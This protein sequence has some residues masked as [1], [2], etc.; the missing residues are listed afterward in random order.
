MKEWVVKSFGAGSSSKVVVNSVEVSVTNAFSVLSEGENAFDELLRVIVHVCDFKEKMTKESIV[1]QLIDND[2]SDDP[3]LSEAIDE[4]DIA[5]CENLDNNQGLELNES[6][7]FLEQRQVVVDT[8]YIEEILP[9]ELQHEER[10]K[11]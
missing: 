10:V 6:A 2:S 11:Q 1:E 9:G 3:A 4:I 8:D 5:R 7:T